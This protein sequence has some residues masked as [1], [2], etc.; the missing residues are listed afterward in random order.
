MKKRGQKRCSK[1]NAA[2]GARSFACKACSH[3]FSVKVA[4]KKKVRQIGDWRL[5]ERD[6]L[7]RVVSGSGPYYVDTQG[8]RHYFTDR[9]VYKV[10]GVDKDGLH[11]YPEKG[12]GYSYLYMGPE[13]PSSLAS[14]MYR[15]PHKILTVTRRSSPS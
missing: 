9:G 15:A 4:R 2:N 3:P 14:N 10:F 6:A 8:N 12:G 1:C 7:I 13:A 11:C 5:L